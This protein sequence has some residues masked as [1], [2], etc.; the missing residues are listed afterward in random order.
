MKRFALISLVVST[1]SFGW[2]QSEG[3]AQPAARIISAVPGI[4]GSTCSPGNSPMGFC[5]HTVANLGTGQP[6]LLERE[7]T[8]VVSRLASN[9][10][11]RHAKT[12]QPPAATKG[13]A[14]HELRL[15]VDAP[16]RFRLTVDHRLRGSLILPLWNHAQ[17]QSEA[18]ISNVVCT[19]TLPVTSGALGL[20]SATSVTGEAMPPLD[21]ASSA[22]IDGVSN[23]QPVEEIIRCEWDEMALGGGCDAAVKLGWYNG[24]T[25]GCT[26]CDYVRG[27]AAAD[28]DFLTVS[29][30]PLP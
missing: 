10:N 6:T 22:T 1:A 21:V 3:W 7:P 30:E 18:A 4:T 13:H 11:R 20:Q 24:S 16:A 29:I 14:V 23:G 26:A 15:V 9:V 2:W 17:C 19:S 5:A 8:R 27:A 28:G 12:R 25:Q